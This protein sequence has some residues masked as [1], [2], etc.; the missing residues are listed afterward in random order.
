MMYIIVLLF[1]FQVRYAYGQVLTED[2]VCPDG[3]KCLG[4]DRCRSSVL[5]QIQGQPQTC[6][7]RHVCCPERTGTVSEHKRTTVD[8]QKVKDAECGIVNTRLSN[9]P[10]TSLIGKET[11]QDVFPWMVAITMLDASTGS[12]KPW[13]TGFLINS[14]QVISAAHC[15]ENREKSL[16]SARIGH[17]DMT[18]GYEYNISRI[19]V[20]PRYE[21]EAYYDDIALLTLSKNV[22]R[23]RFSPVC[24]PGNRAFMNVTGLNGTVAGWGITKIG[25]SIGNILKRQ[26][27]VPVISNYKCS[28]VFRENM[29]T[30]LNKFPK[31][32]PQGFI[33]AG[34]MDRSR[35]SCA[36]DSGGPLMFQDR[37]RWFAIGVVSFGYSCGRTGLPGGYTRISEY[38]TWIKRY[39][40]DV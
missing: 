19:R 11:E 7:R 15:F 29:S 37:G 26:D 39:R 16:Y 23:E 27:D 5:S 35:E 32:I 30:F 4:V 12:A 3:F 21:P 13:C 28:Q 18:K 34:K 8:E 33:C 17:N 2:Q 9:L 22:N 25:E 1:L 14:R 31:G 40:N 38:Q 24:L 36:G 10:T 6:G 20:H